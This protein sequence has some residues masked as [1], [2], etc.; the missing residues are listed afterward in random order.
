M[1]RLLAL[2]FALFFLT[3]CDYTEV[4]REIGYKGKA[5]VNPWLAA[6]RFIGRLGYE[7]YP[8]ISWTEPDDGDAV[9]IVPASVLNNVSFTRSMDEWV[10]DGGHL[11]LLIERTDAATSDWRGRHPAPAIEKALP[12]M[13]RRAGISLEKSGSARADEIEF[14]GIDYKVD[15]GSKAV[16]SLDD[17]EGGVFVSTEC[18]DGRITVITDGRIF[19]NRW[20]GEKDHA[21][22]MAALLDA[23][24]YDGRV[25]IV[26]DSGLSFWSLLREHL[27]PILLAGAVMLVLWLWRN[28][29]R[30]GP[31]ESAAPPPVSRGYEHHLEALGCF[32]WKFDRGAAL[33][34]QLRAQ[35]AEFGHRACFAAG[36]GD[37][38]LQ[39]FLAERAGLPQERVA[40]ALLDSAPHDPNAFT[41]VTADLQKLLDTLHQPS[42]P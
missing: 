15:A 6:E 39:S 29:S 26:R 28:M 36:R 9:W 23:G 18:G 34:A 27:S 2:A 7:T 21:A 19:R 25:G 5:R 11:I 38:D 17:G 33:L 12:D 16:V 10:G 13:L 24:G 31:V 37:G 4:E 20:I 40:R 22:L 8:V 30:F 3:G 32:H 1:I 42:M 35:V 41:L 14:N